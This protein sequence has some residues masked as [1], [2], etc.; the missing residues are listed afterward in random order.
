MSK[1]RR[2]Q[3]ARKKICKALVRYGVVLVALLLGR[4]MVD[5]QQYQISPDTLSSCHRI[6]LTTDE[7]SFAACHAADNNNCINIFTIT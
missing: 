7:A 1:K 5:D 4:N 2:K 6:A 3:K